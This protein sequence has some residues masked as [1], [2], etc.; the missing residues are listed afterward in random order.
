MF[1]GLF[2]ANPPPASAA[3]SV[4]ADCVPCW[5]RLYDAPSAIA[6]AWTPQAPRPS[7]SC[8]AHQQHFSGLGRKNGHKNF[9]LRAVW[10]V[11]RPLILSEGPAYCAWLVPSEHRSPSDVAF[12]APQGP[13]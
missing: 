3:D 12:E 6:A 5:K 4:S 11:P 2:S 9:S 8:I 7:W 10:I 1:D 13:L